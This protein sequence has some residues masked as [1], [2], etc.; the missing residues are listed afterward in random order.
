MP[1]STVKFVD[2][3]I[4]PLPS[5]SLISGASSVSRGTVIGSGNVLDTAD[6]DASYITIGESAGDFSVVTF[7]AVCDPPIPPGSVIQPGGLPDAEVDYAA[8]QEQM[9]YLVAPTMPSV[10]P[11][12]PISPRFIIFSSSGT[13]CGGSATEGRS[14]ANTAWGTSYWDQTNAGTTGGPPV[15]SFSLGLFEAGFFAFPGPTDYFFVY[16]NEGDGL[17]ISQIVGQITWQPGAVAWHTVG[18]NFATVGGVTPQIFT[19]GVGWV[20][21]VDGPA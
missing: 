7:R 8:F 10:P 13:W 14:N 1:T 15:F 20:D 11:N 9:R 2:F 3:N 6:G 12:A 16:T 21:V 17:A 5:P 18:G 19:P 4:D